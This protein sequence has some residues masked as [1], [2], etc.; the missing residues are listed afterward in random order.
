M[1]EFSDKNLKNFDD[2]IG[3]TLKNVI[4]LTGYYYTWK[5]TSPMFD[6]NKP[7]KTYGGIIAQELNKLFPKLV[8][9][10]NIGDEEYLTVDYNGLTMLLLES[11]KELNNMLNEQ[12][13]I[14]DSL[15]NQIKTNTD[16]INQINI[17]LATKTVPTTPLL[18]LTNIPINN[19]K[20]P[21]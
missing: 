6:I 9:T 5:S 12:K 18:P 1:Q 4:H 15:S 17:I 19:I 20:P 10:M 14:N 3:E 11:I 8:S 13:E 2:K 21:K 16:M 7:L